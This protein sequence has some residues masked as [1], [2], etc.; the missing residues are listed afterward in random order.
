MARQQELRGDAAPT[1][2]TGTSDQF[3]V[4]RRSRITGGRR[5]RSTEQSAELTRVAS[6]GERGNAAAFVDR[7]VEQGVDVAGA[8]IVGSDLRLVEQVRGPSGWVRSITNAAAT[9]VLFGMVL[10]LLLGLFDPVAPG[11]SAFF[12]MLFGGVLGLVMGAVWGALAHSLRGRD[13]FDSRMGLVAARY[14]VLVE[15]DVEPA[16]RAAIEPKPPLETEHT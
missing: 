3:R 15:R 2:E 16:A 12:G 8:R 14:D 9:G 1:T 5:R 11:T 4:T 13:Q 7:L 10:G 6:F